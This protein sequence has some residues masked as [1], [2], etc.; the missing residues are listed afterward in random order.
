MYSEVTCNWRHLSSDGVALRKGFLSRLGLPL[1]ACKFMQS[2]ARQ[3]LAGCEIALRIDT[4][5]ET[6]PG[7]SASSERRDIPAVK[8]LH[9]ESVVG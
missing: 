4:K 6:I 7:F 5:V 1:K 9:Q 8:K 3:N 2:V